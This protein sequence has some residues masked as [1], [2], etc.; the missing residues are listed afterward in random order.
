MKENGF[1]FL[2]SNIKKEN[3]EESLYDSYTYSCCFEKE[4]ITQGIKNK[5]ALA[6]HLMFGKGFFL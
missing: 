3:D 6:E 5:K 4:E 1:L 2:E